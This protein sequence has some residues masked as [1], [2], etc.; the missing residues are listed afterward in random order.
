MTCCSEQVD[1]VGR[2]R[3]SELLR[4]SSSRLLSQSYRWKEL[5]ELHDRPSDPASNPLCRSKVPFATKS[6]TNSRWQLSYCNRGRGFI[7]RPVGHPEH[8]DGHLRIHRAVESNKPHLTKQYGNWRWGMP[9]AT[10]Q[11]GC[12]TVEGARSRT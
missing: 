12:R 6:N 3:C 9:A 1:N 8:L 10:L 11:G 4:S 5:D 7:V 2:W